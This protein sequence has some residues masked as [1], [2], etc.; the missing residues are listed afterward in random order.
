MTG[1]TLLWLSGNPPVLAEAV[2]ERIERP[3]SQAISIRQ[4]SQKDQT[5]WQAEQEQMLARYSTLEQEIAR[6]EEQKQTLT[7]SVTAARQRVDA[8]QKQ[9]ADT[10]QIGSEI[11]PYIRTLIRD[12]QDDVEHGSPFLMD[13]R[14]ARL[15]R[16]I[17]L[18]KDPEV[19]ISEKF[20]KTMEALMI[21][22]EYAR[23]IEVYQQTI[24][25]DSRDMQVNIF[26]LGRLSVFFQTL[27]RKTCGWFNVATKKWEPLPVRYNTAIFEAIEMGAKRRP[28][29]LL[30]LPIGRMAL[31]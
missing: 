14:R 31:P 15:A 27:D 11:V 6:L 25:I 7:E 17:D 21:E 3:V 26:R 12:M 9:L 2:G 22:A 24:T 5:Q 23:T 16:L 13:E 8:K 19:A 29:E 18:S 28:V 1:I 10:E 4:Q 20:R 30:T